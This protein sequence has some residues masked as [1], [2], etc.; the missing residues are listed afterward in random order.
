M[1][2]GP[3]VAVVLLLGCGPKMSSVDAGSGCAATGCP[4]DQRCDATTNLCVALSRCTTACGGAKPFCDESR[5]ACVACTATDGCASTTPHCNLNNPAGPVCV[6]C[7]D[8]THCPGSTCVLS[9]RTCAS[10]PDAGTPPV[11]AGVVDAGTTPSCGRCSGATSKCEPMSQRCVQCLQDVDCGGSRLCDPTTFTCVLAPS[12]GGVCVMTPPPQPCTPNCN[13]GFTC[14]NSQCVLNG[15]GGPVQVTVRWDTDTD[16][17]LHLDEPLP[18]GGVCEIYYGDTG[19][20]ASSC[21]AVGSLDLDSN[22]GCS[23]DSVDI[24]NIIYPSG[25]PAPRG[26]YT[27][28]VDYYDNCGVNVAIPYEIEVRANGSTIGW[29]DVFVPG[30]ADSGGAGDGR[31]ITSFVVP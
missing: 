25:Q 7:L 24:E 29:C 10:H 1:R 18:D 14:V 26:Q 6:E 15:G 2:F 11:D 23:I 22:A 30:D 16:V 3:L 13:E 12:D 4:A 9:T 17:D 8:D 21:G 19:G 31:V 27:V 20:A 5:G 28:R